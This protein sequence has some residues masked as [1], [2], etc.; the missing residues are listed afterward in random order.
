MLP[1][2]AGETNEATCTP[3]PVPRT[4]LAPPGTGWDKRAQGTEKETASLR[5]HE[6]PTAEL[7]QRCRNPRIGEGRREAELK[8]QR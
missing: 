2:E 8:W 3:P 6:Q 7:K 4:G 5:S 1:S